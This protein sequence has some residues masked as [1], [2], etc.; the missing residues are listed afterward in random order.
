[1]SLIVSISIFLGIS[2]NVYQDQENSNF[3]LPKLVFENS[4]IQEIILISIPTVSAFLTS[5]Y[6]TNTW[7]IRKEKLELRRKILGEVDNSLVNS[8]Q[9]LKNFSRL[10]WQE[11]KTNTSNKSKEESDKSNLYE[12]KFPSDKS[13]HPNPKFKKEH[14]GF[15]TKYAEDTFELWKF[16]STV[17]LY[18]EEKLF[19]DFDKIVKN[20]EPA[21]VELEKLYNSN[22]GAEFDLFH[23][24]F[25]AIRKDIEREII[26]FKEKLI[27]SKIKKL[28][29]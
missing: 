11:Y 7:Q 4:F 13:E 5:L 1:M 27:A 8:L 16:S 21:R 19:E 23:N 2:F 24:R 17:K 10:L 14:D 9:T 15:L 22:S 26:Q 20:L 3:L 28:N 6:V 12:I 25:M 18:Y 29:V